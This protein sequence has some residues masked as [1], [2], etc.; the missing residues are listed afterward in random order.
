M[1]QRAGARR[2]VLLMAYGTPRN[3]DEVEPY[4]RD[5]RGGRTPS[6]EAV[7]ELRERYRRVGGQTPLLAYTRSV[8]GRLEAR[9]NSQT[10]D[11]SWRVF[12]GMKHWH[13][14]IAEAVEKIGAAGVREL[15]ALPLAPH[16]SKLSIGGYAE[17]AH[18]ALARLADPPA[19]TLIESWH[20]NPLFIE[21]IAERIGAALGRIA[22]PA[23]EVAVVFTA[24]SLPAAIVEAGD[25]YPQELLE[26]AAAAARAA[27][28]QSWRFAYQSAGKTAMPWL[29]PD[30]LEAM[31]EIAGEGW[32]EILVVPF[33]F[34][35]DHL[36]ILYDIDIEAQERARELGVKLARIAMPNDDPRF[37][38]VLFDLA[39]SGT[40]ARTSQLGTAAPVGG[41]G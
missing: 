39:R 19:T 1:P 21:L 35:C 8:A 17:R 11:D 20:A 2:G 34:V 26:S 38:N 14:Y 24:H 4:Y 28:V 27:G 22:A 3:L 12:V 32:R 13:P 10:G 9:L 40:G 18:E 6:P 25:P 5:I 41:G 15:T 16:Y 7:A 37:I 36:E 31:A 29:G 30:I 23:A 33:G